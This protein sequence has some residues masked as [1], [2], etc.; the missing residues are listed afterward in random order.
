MLRRSGARAGHRGAPAFIP[1]RSPRVE[2]RAVSPGVI[3][4]ASLVVAVTIGF[5]LV[6]GAPIVGVPVMVLGLAAFGFVE[7]RRRHRR[8]TDIKKFRDEAASRK[9]EFTARD[10]QTQVPENGF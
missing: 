2:F 1:A 10:R 4:V 9:T 7:F 5:G 3:T 8:D 6:W